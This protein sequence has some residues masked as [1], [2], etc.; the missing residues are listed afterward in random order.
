MDYIPVTQDDRKSMLEAIGASSVEDLFAQVPSDCRLQR[1]LNL[2]QAMSEPELISHLTGLAARNKN[3]DQMPC[4]LGAGA[5][6][7]FVPAIVEDV[8]GKSELYT[9]YTP[10]QA[11]ISQGI[12][13]VIY[14]FQT[15]MCEL[16]AMDISNASLYDGAT[17]LSEAV[18][19][20]IHASGCNRVVLAGAVNPQYAQTVRTYLGGLGIS[21]EQVPWDS[22][23]GQVDLQALRGALRESAACVVVQHP[24]FFGLLEPMDEI[25][26]TS[27]AAGAQVI[28]SVDPISLGLLKPPGEFGV[29]I[30]VG[31]AQGL[32]NALSF[33]GPYVGFLACTDRYMRRIPGR[34]VG[35]A[36]DANGR[37]GFALVLQTREQH[38]RRGRATSNI[39][40][41]Q[42]LCALIAAAYLEAMG[43]HGLREV[44]ELCL[45]KAH[46]CAEQIDQLSGF[47]LR[48][49]APFFKE[50]VVTC[51][52]D[53]VE[54][55]KRL[56]QRGTI[57][58]LPLS[59]LPGQAAQE[60]AN[61]MLICV[62]EQRTR[63]QIDDFV[64]ALGESAT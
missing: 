5:Y 10:Y 44:A 46:Y 50:F 31:E 56:L 7:H 63:E 25:S 33:G 15:L 45:Q 35:E 37:R 19:M 38:I 22:K 32:G 24:N 11:E 1:L 55:N 57:G 51:P 59:K 34:V 58:G 49:P 12:L 2:P 36:Y 29:D 47:S 53:P 14:E 3:V 64:K 23:S 43:K 16:T 27:H 42:A 60:P 4:F 30:A 9:A 17:A 20:A 6:D 21:V 13:Q 39:C 26:T 62:T 18:L 48:F 52:S 8:A 28:A 40:T 54:I 61:A 41:N